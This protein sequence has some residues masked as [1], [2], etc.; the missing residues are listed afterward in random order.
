[1]KARRKLII[2]ITHDEGYDDVP[3]RILHFRDGKIVV[4]QDLGRV[5]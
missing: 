3:D 5:E 2:A 4:H 1:M